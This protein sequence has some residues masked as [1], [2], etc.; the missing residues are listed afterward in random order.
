[1][2]AKSP[3]QQKMMAMIAHGKLKKKGVSK[4]VA[5]EFSHKPKGGYK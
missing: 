2:P 5:K 1:M 3:K 4:A